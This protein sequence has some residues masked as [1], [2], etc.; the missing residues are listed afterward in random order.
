MALTSGACINENLPI[1]R[2]R[3]TFYPLLLSIPVLF[4]VESRAHITTFYRTFSRFRSPK[5]PAGRASAGRLFPCCLHPGLADA[6]VAAFQHKDWS[7]RSCFAPSPRCC[8]GSLTIPDIWAPRSAL[9]RCCIP[10][11]RTSTIIRIST[12]L[13]PV[14]VC[15]LTSLDG[16]LAGQALQAGAGS[17]TPVPATVSRRAQAD[18]RQRPASVLQRLPA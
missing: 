17:V 3:P 7:I 1:N 9:S 5:Q 12:A 2:R 14:E 15:H 6:E 4:S 13:C 16:L 11:V 10:G 8:A 18:L